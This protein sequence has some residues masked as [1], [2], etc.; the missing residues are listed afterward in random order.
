[1]ARATT[2]RTLTL[3]VLIIAVVAGARVG[4]GRLFSWAPDITGQWLAPVRERVVSIAQ[5]LLLGQ[6]AADRIRD[7]DAKNRAL[8][9]A[10]AEHDQIQRD[11]QF[12]QD[13]AKIRPELS[14]EPLFANIFSYTRG[15]GSVQAILNRGSDDRVVLGD[16]VVTAHRELIGTVAQV[17]AHHAVVSVL[18]DSSITV[19]ARVLQS[20]ISGLVRSEPGA[21]VILDLIRKDEH[22]SEGAVVVTSGDDRFP[23]G[24]ILGTIRSTDNE[25]APLFQVVRI[26]PA[27]TPGVRGPVIILHQ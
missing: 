26:S 21:K 15:G 13:V 5:S 7:L 8:T 1:M 27:V 20:E 12:Y 16:V 25:V 3:A 4:A 2:S 14:G 11:A 18:G 24:L 23:A 17:F 22:I 19:T 9:A 6:D 10:I